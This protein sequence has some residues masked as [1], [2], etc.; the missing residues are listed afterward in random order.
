MCVAGAD[1][2]GDYAAL[3]KKVPADQ[4]EAHLAHWRTSQ[5][6]DPDAWILSAN[7]SFEQAQSESIAVTTQP[8]REG[9]LAVTDPKTGK[10]VGSLSTSTR[11]D[12]ERL[13][14]ATGLLREAAKRWPQRLDIHCGL[15]HMLE[16]SGAWGE[17]LDAM[18]AL[19]AAVREHPGKLRWCH[20]EPLDAPESAFVASKLHSYALHQ[21]EKETPETDARFHTVAKLIVASFPDSAL[22]H[23][24]LA[25]FHGLKKN[26]RAVQ[27]AL[28][29]AA[30]AA[31]EDALV[32]ANLGDNSVRLSNA[33]RARTA[34]EK[35]IALNSDLRMVTHAQAGL[36]KLTEAR[37]RKRSK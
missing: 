1:Y 17:Q 20:G 35:V 5:P 6:E 29:A 37:P 26:W 33:K 25:I 4:M 7:W 34:Y 8:A 31:P 2:S 16:A 15:A 12:P 13:K 19:L 18:R 21:F 27:T 14:T 23:N 3:K 28:E 22:G 32:W 30:K 9:D 24:D 36:A 10:T 11:A